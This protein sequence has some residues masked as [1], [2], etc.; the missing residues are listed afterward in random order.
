MKKINILLVALL[1]IVQL[2]Q[3]QMIVYNGDTL[4]Y[5]QS[6]AHIYQ[7][8]NLGTSVIP[9]GFLMEYSLAGF[10][11]LNHD[12][13]QNDPA[14]NTL[15]DFGMLWGSLELGKVNGN[16]TINTYENALQTAKQSY[17]AD[18]SISLFFINKNYH[19]IKDHAYS[20]NLL[21][22]D[23]PNIQIKEGPVFKGGGE[24]PY[25]QD[26]LF[27]LGLYK[28]KIESFDAIKFRMPTAAFEQGVSANL[29]VNF[30]DGQGF[31]QLNANT[32]YTINY[33]TVGTKNISITDGNRTATATI[34]FD[35][36]EIYGEPSYT[37]TGQATQKHPDSDS[38]SRY[39]A[40]VY[41][42]CGGK[43]DKP[44]VI[45]EGFDV[46]D[47][48]GTDE[49]FELF[50]EKRD[51]DGLN[52]NIYKALHHLGYDLIFVNLPDNNSHIQSNAFA[53]E[54]LLNRI[55]TLAKNEPGSNI[56]NQSSNYMQLMGLSMGGLV[57]R[58]CLREMEQQSNKKHYVKNYFSYDSPHQ[59]ANISMGLQG[60]FSMM[61]QHF[62]L[63][64][65]DDD[66]N[67]TYSALNSPAANQ[68]FVR[69]FS[70]IP[71]VR[72]QFASGLDA[73]GLPNETTANYALSLGRGDNVGISTSVY[74]QKLI[75]LNI[76]PVI[77]ALNGK[78]W[79]QAQP[80]NFGLIADITFTMFPF[81]HI[82]NIPF[83]AKSDYSYDIVAGSFRPVQYELAAG[84]NPAWHS[85]ANTHNSEGLTFLPA[86][87]ALNL[88]NQQYGN[89]NLWF[90]QNMTYNIDANYNNLSTITDFDDVVTASMNPATGQT[91]EN[92][93]HTT[94]HQNMVNFIVEKVTGN[95][96]NIN[97][98]AFC[99]TNPIVSGQSIVCNN[100][101]ATFDLTNAMETAGYNYQWTFNQQAFELVSG[102]GTPS[103]S[104]KAKN[105]YNG[106][107]SVSLQIGKQGC[108]SDINL[109]SDIWVGKP[110][111]N[112]NFDVNGPEYVSYGSLHNYSVD[113]IQGATSYQWELPSGWSIPQGNP[114]G[115]FI[116]VRIG[117]DCGLKN[118][119]VKPINSCDP[120]G[121][122]NGSLNLYVNVTGCPGSGPS[123]PE[124]PCIIADPLRLS[125]NPSNGTFTLDVTSLADIQPSEEY[126]LKIYSPYDELVYD[127]THRQKRVQINLRNLETGIH[128]VILEYRGNLVSERMLVQ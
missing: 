63:V 13:L 5:E 30:D 14:L 38:Y 112:F 68:M 47:D 45:V 24:V 73:L 118:I 34:E 66:F 2:T 128:Q 46:L 23:E 54:A 104:L 85:S 33:A 50:D 97:C 124:P 90:S 12:G 28:N 72:Q 37:L 119:R 40:A 62:P 113:P 110:N 86:V 19:R 44:F 6:K 106:Y 114:N 99:Q 57:N 101:T 108:A 15:S 7:D 70:P 107:A 61:Y 4:D 94:V 103:V 56:T 32:T 53:I 96:P 65:T 102:Q 83:I 3:A 9:T 109:N 126:S 26:R 69:H 88:K 79:A 43:L 75:T 39:E 100:A 91:V 95:P 41:Q 76:A 120:N 116:T 11:H 60:L 27:A 127:R 18:R 117:D 51:G 48:I 77:A 22:T 25:V 98:D 29:Q 115:S 16:G 87:S 52:I 55:H 10:E 89:N 36:P 8:L 67:R 105:Q 125:P 111:L 74:G 58:W 92:Y 81:S 80:G 1:C 59:G 49:L 121:N 123:C 78:A 82:F 71:N 93:R 21:E 20:Q 84:I 64:R 17:Q 31:R 35:R 122:Q 42:G